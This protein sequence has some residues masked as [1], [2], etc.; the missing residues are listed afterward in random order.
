MIILHQYFLIAT[1]A[2]TIA[3]SALAYFAFRN[4]ISNYSKKI[5][6]ILFILFPI[7]VFT[8]IKAS[9]GNLYIVD[10]NKSVAFYNIIGS[11]NFEVNN[12]KIRVNVPRNKVG[13]LN[14]SESDLVVKEIQ[15]SSSSYYT[16]SHFESVPISAFSFEKC[17]LNRGKIDYFF[18]DKIPEEITTHYSSEDTK[19]QLVEAD[20]K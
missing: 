7:I 14:L 15:Y 1:I 18:D 5:K 19:Y 9:S 12:K 17:F 13:I 8:L 3:I 11:K 6:Q 2:V 20:E 4:F 16:K 10:N